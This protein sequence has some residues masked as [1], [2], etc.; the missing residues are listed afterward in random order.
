MDWSAVIEFVLQELRT[1]RSY[2][3]FIWF[4]DHVLPNSHSSALLSRLSWR[5]SL[6][7]VLLK[8]CFCSGYDAFGSL[9]LSSRKL[10]LAFPFCA[11]HEVVKF[12]LIW[13]IEA[14]RSVVCFEN[15]EALWS[16]V[17]GLC[18]FPLFILK[19]HQKSPLKNYLSHFPFLL[20]SMISAMSAPGYFF[21]LSLSFTLSNSF[22]SC[23]KDQLSSGFVSS[24]RGLRFSCSVVSGATTCGSAHAFHLYQEWMLKCC[25]FEWKLM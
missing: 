8:L 7:N 19:L 22:S 15:S 20:S 13:L 4:I 23:H 14:Q 16:T 9:C 21:P 3:H 25:S 18:L 5:P 12:V 24:P 11:S 6:S 1:T 10:K 17:P 2:S